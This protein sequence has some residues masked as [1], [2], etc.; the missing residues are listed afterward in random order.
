MASETITRNDLTAI[1]NSVLPNPT[2]MTPQ[3][4]ED[5]IDSLLGQGSNI[6]DFV[7]E[8]DTETISGVVWTYRKWN[9]GIAECWSNHIALTVNFAQ[10]IETNL[11]TT[12][13]T[14]AV[15]YPSIFTSVDSLI[16][17]ASHGVTNGWVTCT[18]G[19]LSSGTVATSWL[20]WNSGGNQ[21]VKLNV[22]LKGKWK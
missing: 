5:F 21:S 8:E 15:T 12:G 9:S 7:V 10:N 11:Y 16:C 19:S 20:G 13:Y 3:E 18:A 14:Y 4:V 6:A 17:S 2:D 1:L 22:S